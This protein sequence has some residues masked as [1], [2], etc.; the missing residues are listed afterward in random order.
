MEEGT[1]CMMEEDCGFKITD[2]IRCS[3]TRAWDAV[4]SRLGNNKVCQ[5]E[6]WDMPGYDG[7]H[8]IP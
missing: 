2:K 1:E 5:K 6:P 4:R 8:T 7:L 3:A